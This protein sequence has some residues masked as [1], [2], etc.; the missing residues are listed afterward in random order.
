MH[1]ERLAHGKPRP[2]VIYTLPMQRPLT[3]L[4]ACLALAVLI[5]GAHLWSQARRD[6]L[7]PDIPG[8]LTLKGDFHMHTTTSDGSVLPAVRVQEAWRDGLDVIALT[9]HIEYPSSGA[10][11]QADGNRPYAI[12]KPVADQYGLLLIRAAEITGSMPSSRHPG[13]V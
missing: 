10:D 11:S 1:P 7:I 4:V 5:S 12:A 3:R 6:L 2:Q 13:S 9:D 8:F